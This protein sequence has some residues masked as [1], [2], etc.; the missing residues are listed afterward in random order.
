MAHSTTLYRFFI[1]SV[2][3]TSLITLIYGI[4]QAPSKTISSDLKEYPP[5]RAILTVC[6]ILQLA[7]F[8]ICLYCK[9]RFHPD[10]VVWG[11]I[12]AVGIGVAWIGLSTFLE[13]TTHIA[14]VAMFM[15]FTVILLF[16]LYSITWQI[17]ALV[18]LKLT[19]LFLILVSICMTILVSTDQFYIIE[20]V[21]FIP[22]NISFTWLFLVH[23]SQ[24]WMEPDP[25]HLK[26]ESCEHLLPNII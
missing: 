14:F 23:D 25:N 10:A 16:I 22:Y 9:E 12:T 8:L 24:E 6:L 15:S 2:G 13:G 7:I 21:G 11:Y 1:L 19:I 3:L 18:I 5:F 17:T 26:Y 4:T 20:F